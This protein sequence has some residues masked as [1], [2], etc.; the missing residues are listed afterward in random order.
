MRSR[1][2]TSQ[3]PWR[4]ILLLSLLAHIFI[5][6]VLWPQIQSLFEDAQAPPG[7]RVALSQQQAPT[8]Q[9]EPKSEPEKETKKKP[10]KLESEQKQTANDDKPKSEPEPEEVL[11]LPRDTHDEVDLDGTDLAAPEEEKPLKAQEDS[12]G[13]GGEQTSP[14]L[15]PELADRQQQEQKQPSGER[16]RQGGQGSGESGR[17]DAEASRGEDS[18]TDSD[19]PKAGVPE[20][21][22]EASDEPGQPESERASMAL[23]GRETAPDSGPRL[24]EDKQGAGDPGEE[25]MGAE[26]GGS[27]VSEIAQRRIRMANEYL[28]RMKRQIMAQWEQPDDA[29]ARHRGEIRFS[30]DSRGYL[31]ASLL[32]LPSGHEELDESALRAVRAVE[33]YRVPESPS[34]VRQYYQDLRFTFSGAPI[35]EK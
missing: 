34:I 14:E 35:N 33:R 4:R 2:A 19:Q 25:E 17:A 11:H 30:V 22:S 8:E 9:P 10:E 16:T 27:P 32:N 1:A 6:T 23:G 15:R 3:G 26:R 31:R 7:M 13:Q 12:D 20:V 21:A 18:E 5:G 29:R 24:A 28:A